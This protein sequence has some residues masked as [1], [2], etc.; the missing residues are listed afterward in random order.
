[1]LHTKSSDYFKNASI[2]KVGGRTEWMASYANM[3]KHYALVQGYV[4]VTSQR[5]DRLVQRSSSSLGIHFAI[6][7]KVLV[8]LLD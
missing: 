1:M 7:A 4:L 6:L 2:N 3:H 8:K 5:M